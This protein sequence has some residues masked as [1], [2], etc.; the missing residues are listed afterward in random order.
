M[1]NRPS[2]SPQRFPAQPYGW[3]CSLLPWRRIRPE[4]RTKTCSRVTATTFQFDDRGHLLRIQE[5][6]GAEGRTPAA[7]A[8]CE[9]LGKINERTGIFGQPYAIRF[10]MRLPVDWNGKFFFE[11]GGGSNGNLG[12]AYGNLQGGQRENALQLGYAVVS[13]DSGHDNQVNNDPERGGTTTFGF[14]PQARVDF[15]YNSYDQVTQVAKAMI[16]QHYGRAPERSYYVGCSEGG[17]EAMMMSQRFPD[18]FDGILACAP[19]MSLQ[20]V[21][22]FGHSWDVQSFA[23]AAEAIGVEGTA[24]EP[25]LNKTFTDEDL[26]LAAKA[27]LKRVTAST[28][29]RMASSTTLRLH[30]GRGRS[31]A[32]AITCAGA[33]QASCST[34]IQVATLKRV[35]GGA[36]NSD[37]ESFMPTGPGIAASAASCPTATTW[38]GG[39][40]RS[41]CTVAAE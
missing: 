18:Y 8:H 20:E 32:A 39:S 14:D 21:A 37:G 28:A 27:V 41:A 26:D 19:G 16:R 38:A 25:L 1:P 15:G 24:G 13:T 5:A 3:A 11:G 36:R 40:G 29:W 6:H 35:Y 12:A 33:K 7:P 34:R 10:H 22:L 4:T 2:G 31:G 9:V 17:R 23:A 30:D